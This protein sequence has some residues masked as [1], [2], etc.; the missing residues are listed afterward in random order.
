[1]NFKKNNSKSGELQP[2]NP[3]NG[4]YESFGNFYARLLGGTKEEFP[5]NFPKEDYPLEYLKLYYNEDIDWNDIIIPE[6]KMN[7]LI[8]V[9]NDKKRFLI[10]RNL[11]GYNEENIGELEKQIFENAS[12][13]KPFANGVTKYGFRVKI[14]MPIKFANSNDQLIIKTCRIIKENSKP[15][16]VTAWYEKDFKEDFKDEI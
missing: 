7:F 4:E 14:F 12:R 3:D 11:L 1:M 16:F 6:G 5:L 13:Y 15:S 2:Y 10:F 8:D 9:K